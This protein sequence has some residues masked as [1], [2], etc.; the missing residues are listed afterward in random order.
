MAP[1]VGTGGAEV[2]GAVSV[3]ATVGVPDGGEVGVGS[4]AW[5]T[6][7]VS[8]GGV[9]WLPGGT[10][11]PTVGGLV[12]VAVGTTDAV[13]GAM[14]VAVAHAPAASSR[15]VT[16]RIRRTVRMGLLRLDVALR[17][18]RGRFGSRVAPK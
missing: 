8:V 11:G 17:R 1:G 2:G 13:G 5:V 6:P 14:G 18:R 9:D 12:G 3:G 7:G 4:T 10:L 16:D 15:T